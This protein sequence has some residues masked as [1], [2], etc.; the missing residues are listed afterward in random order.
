MTSEHLQLGVGNQYFEVPAEWLYREPPLLNIHLGCLSHSL[1]GMKGRLGT[2]TSP[3]CTP[4]S[5]YPIS[6]LTLRASLLWLAC[7][8]PPVASCELPA[9]LLML[10]PTLLLPLS[11]SCPGL[12][13][14]PVWSQIDL[15][16]NPGHAHPLWVPG[17][18]AQTPYVSMSHS[19]MSGL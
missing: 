15:T 3:D 11:G 7:L 10:C 9:D 13:L 17:P 8:P 5:C 14:F 18:P 1:A 12:R 6:N 4:L 16:P 19:V 2:E